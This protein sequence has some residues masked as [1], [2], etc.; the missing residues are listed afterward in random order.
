MELPDYLSTEVCRYPVALA[1]VDPNAM[2]RA[3][4][5][6]QFRC[7]PN[8]DSFPEEK[9]LW[10]T[11]L[12]RLMA[13]VIY[14]V[15]L[16]GL[17]ARTP[18][19]VEFLNGFQE[20]A[21]A[22][23]ALV[24]K[25]GTSTERKAALADCIKFCALDENIDLCEVHSENACDLLLGVADRQDATSTF[26]RQVSDLVVLSERRLS[27]SLRR[28]L[29]LNDPKVPVYR[30]GANHFYRS[31]F[32]ATGDILSSSPL[33]AAYVWTLAVRLAKKKFIKFASSHRFDVDPILHITPHRL[34]PGTDVN[35]PDIAAI[36]ALRTDTLYY[37]AE[38]DG[39]HDTHPRMDLWF[40]TP[41]DQVVFIDIAGGQS[42]QSHK[43][44]V[45]KLQA[46]IDDW[47]QHSELKGMTFEGVVLAPGFVGPASKPAC[48]E[49]G[50]V[51][52]VLDKEARKLLGGLDQVYRWFDSAPVPLQQRKS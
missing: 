38:K 20:K 47:N 21:E 34:F 43:D 45:K 27:S 51:V 4:P 40:R 2:M 7:P 26:D 3:V 25:K 48:Q 37:A 9:R 8:L 6:L 35:A 17:H 50:Q 10:S 39:V 11:L 18:L 23:S 13:K 14:D 24:D 16:A 36:K 41:S 32:L 46:L 44:K 15:D 22:F 52:K 42:R 31:A 33:E 12:F 49:P 5:E 19:A 30:Q 29:K 1:Y 28:L